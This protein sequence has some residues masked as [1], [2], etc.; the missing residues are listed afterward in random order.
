MMVF[1]GFQYQQVFS[2][3]LPKTADMLQVV[4][5][6]ELYNITEW[7]DSKRLRLAR[8]KTEAALHVDRRKNKSIRENVVQTQESLSYLSVHLDRNMRMDNRIR[9][10][11]E[12]AAK[13]LASMRQLTP[14]TQGPRERSKEM[15]A[16][17]I[18]LIIFYIAPV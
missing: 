2:D 5:Q 9:F 12:K 7:L 8:H 16:F 11:V 3:W 4:S 1:C 10:T 17:V 18:Q 15:Y 14:K 13:A 6:H